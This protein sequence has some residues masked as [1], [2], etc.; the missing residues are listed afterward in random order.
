M[1]TAVGPAN[2]SGTRKHGVRA[3]QHP[4]TMA[5]YGDAANQ[6]ADRF[7]LGSLA[8]PSPRGTSRQPG[9]DLN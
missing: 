8:T 2:L 1:T 4:F 5:I 7:I 3:G 9:Q 6:M